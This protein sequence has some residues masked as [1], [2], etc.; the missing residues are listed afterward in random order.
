MNAVLEKPKFVSLF[1]GVGGFDRG[2]ELAGF[3]C[4]GQVE[5]HPF[6][7]AVLEKHWPEVPKHNDIV[8]AVEWW[9]SQDRPQIE[10]V[11][12]GFPCQDISVAKADRKGLDGERSGLYWEALR[13]INVVRPRF[14][15]LENVEGLLSSSSGG[16]LATILATLAECGYPYVEWRVLDSQYFGVPQRRVRVFLVASA[17][18]PRLGPVLLEPEGGGGDIAALAKARQKAVKAAARRYGEGVEDGVAGGPEADTDGVRAAAGL[19]GRVDHLGDTAR[20]ITTSGKRLDADT[21]NFVANIAPDVAATLTHG[22]S[23][24]GVNPPGRRKEDDVNLVVPEN[25]Y[26]EVTASTLQGSVSDDPNKRRGY[27]IDAEGAGG[28]QL[29]VSALT[30]NSAGHAGPDDNEAQAGRLVVVPMGLPTAPDTARALC[31]SDENQR[32]PSAAEPNMAIIATEEQQKIYVKYRNVGKAPAD[33]EAWCP[34]DDIV[35]RTL[36]QSENTIVR[37][38]HAIINAGVQPEGGCGCCPIDPKPDANRYGTMGNAVSVPVIHWI[39]NR[40]WD[41]IVFQMMEEGAEGA[42]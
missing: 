23:S 19:P 6:C 18:D 1:A 30:K 10:L 28:N 26:A 12:G 11:C 4:A 14:F 25:V 5:K 38:P 42:A 32:I 3:E 41:E 17:H 13:F 21:D 22:G 7:L 40:L 2:L 16:D 36:N 37:Q 34:G 8:T 39:G 15:L 27:R 33:D 35:G 31:K 29:V 20:T 24:P 9:E